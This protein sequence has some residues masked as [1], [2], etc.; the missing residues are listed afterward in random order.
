MLGRAYSRFVCKWLRH[1]IANAPSAVTP[2]NLVLCGYSKVCT[3]TRPLDYLEQVVNSIIDVHDLEHRLVLLQSLE[4]S[5]DRVK[6]LRPHEISEE[7]SLDLDSMATYKTVIE[8]R[9]LGEFFKAIGFDSAIFGK[10]LKNST[11][12]SFFH[13]NPSKIGRG[14]IFSYAEVMQFYDYNFEVHFPESARSERDQLIGQNFDRRW[15]KARL[16]EV[17]LKFEAAGSELEEILRDLQ[18]S[19]PDEYAPLDLDMLVGAIAAIQRMLNQYVV[20]KPLIKDTSVA[21]KIASHLP[22]VGSLVKI[23][24]SLL[25]ILNQDGQD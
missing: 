9:Y 24:E 15:Y 16:V 21:A 6:S 7:L 10:K 8:A 12:S 25:N 14:L 13:R 19:D 2:L 5:L 18:Q 4:L 11:Y 22:L 23:L 20:Y 1:F 3:V 17:R